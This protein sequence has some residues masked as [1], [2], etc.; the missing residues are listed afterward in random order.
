LKL[1][2][3]NI[4]QNVLFYMLDFKSP[5]KIYIYKETN[6]VILLDIFQLLKTLTT[7]HCV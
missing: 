2:Q 7:K 6:F 4:K 3:N 5:F 1:Y